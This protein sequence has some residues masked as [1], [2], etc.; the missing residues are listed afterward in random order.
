MTAE[1][2]RLLK[3]YDYNREKALE[4]AHEWAFKRNPRYLDFE[5]LGGD[6]TNFSS[7]TIF[8]GCGVM[9][10]TPV[11]G[12]FYGS[13]SHRTPSW[14]GVNFLHNFLINN[15][16]AGPLGEKVDMDR[17]KPGDLIQLSFDGG[18]HYNHSL[19][20]V[21]TGNRPQLNNIYIATHTYDRDNYALSEYDWKEMRC[22]HIV[23][24]RKG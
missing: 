20:V 13:A 18:N 9:N 12:W 5:N 11:Y 4:Y 10:Y 3:L 14:T 17:V 8:A 2:S 15:K 1:N 23:G 24:V 19:I 22:I 21:R 6:C 16:G 7:Q